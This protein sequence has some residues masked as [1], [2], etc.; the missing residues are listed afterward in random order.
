[1]I[2]GLVD[3][4]VRREVLGWHDLDEKTA[5]ET[6]T[7]V[8]AKEMARDALHNIGTLQVL[9]VQYLR[10][11]D[12]LQAKIMDSQFRKASVENVIQIWTNFLGVKEK[13]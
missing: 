11:K 1:M 8:E 3:D 4:E 12:A 13:R 10:T 6:V 2:S 5:D 9:L 7:F